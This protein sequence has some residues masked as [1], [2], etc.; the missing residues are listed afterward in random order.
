[1]RPE[2]NQH[3]HTSLHV[4]C[5]DFSDSV[6]IYVFT[7]LWQAVSLHKVKAKQ[8]KFLCGHHH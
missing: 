6:T 8:E 2:S 3:L 4:F 7:C 1:M 5:K